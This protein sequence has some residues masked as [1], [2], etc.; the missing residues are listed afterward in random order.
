MWVTRVQREPPTPSAPRSSARHSDRE[1][2]LAQFNERERRG[3]QA[4]IERMPRQ[5]R[6]GP[7][8][9]AAECK[10]WAEPM[11][12]L[13]QRYVGYRRGHNVTLILLDLDQLQRPIGP[14]D[15]RGQ[16]HPGA[17]GII[18]DVALSQAVRLPWPNCETRRK[19]GNAQACFMLRDGVRVDPARL[20]RAAHLLSEVIFR[21]TYW[22]QA[23]PHCQGRVM[24]GLLHRDQETH[25][26][27]AE[28]YTLLELLHALPSPPY[29]FRHAGRLK[30]AA[31]RNDALFRALDRFGAQLSLILMPGSD[32]FRQRVTEEGTRLRMQLPP[33]DHPYTTS[34]LNRTVG[35]VI[36]RTQAGRNRGWLPRDDRAYR[37]RQVWSHNRTPLTLEQ[38]EANICAGSAVANG[39][40]A[41][42]AQERYRAAVT[43]LRERGVAVTAS[44]V[45]LE[46]GVS[47]RAARSHATVWR[48]D[49]PQETE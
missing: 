44:S 24:R 43:R 8:P 13:Q 12:A 40:R 14:G 17:Q 32:E 25:W 34:E 45:A 29:P 31:G 48:T 35:S 23:D 38:R 39:A 46:A 42:S 41:A 2:H 22:F 30:E 1:K 20:T 28:P 27:R 3:Y 19:H 36:R 49:Q 9:A 6:A 37:R 15:K 16:R 10:P 33:G 18:T 26:Y 11:Q 5:P 21:L 47:V 4:L 7:T